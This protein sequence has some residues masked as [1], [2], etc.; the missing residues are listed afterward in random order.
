[1]IV[2]RAYR[3]IQFYDNS[4]IIHASI[5]LSQPLHNITFNTQHRPICMGIQVLDRQ[6]PTG[7]SISYKDMSKHWLIKNHQRKASSNVLIERITTQVK[8]MIVN[9]QN[10]MNE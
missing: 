5:V 9:P 2:K 8:L 7:T 3:K 6:L 1:M 10:V 4:S